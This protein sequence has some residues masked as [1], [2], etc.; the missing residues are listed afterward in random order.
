MPPE[1]HLDPASLDLS[2]TVADREAIR[3][4]SRDFVQ[5]FDKGDAKAIAALWTEQGELYQGGIA[6]RGRT[7]IEEA[8]RE[9]FKQHPNR[10]IEVLIGSIRFP[11]PDLA[12][13]AVH[14]HPVAEALEVYRRLRVPEVWVGDEE[15]VRI[16]VRQATGR[17]AEALQSA[18]L[19]FLKAVEIS[20]WITRPQTVS[21]TEWVKDV[22]RW[23]RE[24][25]VKPR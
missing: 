22:R 6:I 18:A 5:A 23:V 11:A 12:I 15:G 14:T 25:L 2:R 9:L 3:K 19:P 21:E 24:N 20:E 10:R 1:L 7:A 13:E 17:Y 8:F 4:S 16:L